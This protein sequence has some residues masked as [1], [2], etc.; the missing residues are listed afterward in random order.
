MK[1]STYLL[2]RLIY[3]FFGVLFLS[4]AGCYD[5]FMTADEELTPRVAVPK[6]AILAAPCFR[7]GEALTVYNPYDPDLNYYASEHFQVKWLERGA[8]LYEGANTPC[9]CGK[10]LRVVV[11]RLKDNATVSM[12]YT[13]RECAGAA[14]DR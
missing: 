2:K 14:A 4:T 8:V 5:M 13:T 9:V 11:T 1:A 12:S 7:E 3:L 6:I 10:T